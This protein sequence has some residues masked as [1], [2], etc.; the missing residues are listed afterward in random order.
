MANYPTSPIT[1]STIDET[2]PA[3][4]EDASKIDDV[5][6]QTRAVFKGLLGKIMS[7][8][9][10]LISDIV[11]P[12]GS[13]TTN[14][15]KDAAVTETKLGLGAVTAERL[16]DKA[17]TS[18]KLAGD[19]SDNTLRAVDATHIKDGAL[20][21]RHFAT[22][23]VPTAAVV[24]GAITTPKLADLSVTSAK[25]A[26]GGVDTA[27]LGGQVVSAEKLKSSGALELTGYGRL[28][29]DT[30]SE[31]KLLSV[32]ADSEVYPTIVDGRVKFLSVAGVGA[33]QK[34]ALITEK[35]TWGGRP[36]ELLTAVTGSAPFWA[37]TTTNFWTSQ[38]L[39]RPHLK[40]S[41]L[42]GVVA[43]SHLYEDYDPQ[44]LVELVVEDDGTN[45]RSFIKINVA[46]NYYAR[47]WGALLNPGTTTIAHALRLVDATDLTNLIP[48]FTTIPACGSGNEHTVSIGE[49]VLLALPANCKLLVEHKYSQGDNNNDTILGKGGIFGD[50]G[51]MMQ[52]YL[53]KID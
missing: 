3:G 40:H 39:H 16:A 42:G 27:N 23:S 33:F 6:R 29:V 45:I 44:G 15:L 31:V 11:F 4:T 28:Y 1:L 9:G 52:L 8:D 26:V 20:V 13:V 47:L 10:T 48:K 32:H 51:V 22:A 30:G 7:D 17:V 36:T 21:S 53:A 24:D 49:A 38:W 50:V 12:A 2:L 43:E 46:G 5:I 35:G 14:A 34:T 19:A 18:A 25:I 37:T 41:G